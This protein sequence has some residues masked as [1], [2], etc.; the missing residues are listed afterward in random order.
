MEEYNINNIH[1]INSINFIN[2]NDNKIPSKGNN[3]TQINYLNNLQQYTRNTDKKTPKKKITNKYLNSF[4]IPNNTKDS[5]L[6]FDNQDSIPINQLTIHKSSKNPTKIKI[7]NKNNIEGTNSNKRTTAIKTGYVTD[8]PYQ[9]KNLKNSK[10][11]IDVNNNNEKKNINLNKNILEQKNKDNKVLNQNNLKKYI[12]ILKS[13]NANLIKILHRKDNELLDYQKTE[14][15]NE[16]KIKQLTTILYEN[17]NFSKK[18][19]PDGNEVEGGLI[20]DEDN[21]SQNSTLKELKDK[22]D[23]LQKKIEELNNTTKNLKSRYILNLNKKEEEKNKII[24]KY[25][26]LLQEKLNLNKDIQNQNGEI[27]N[28]KN[29]INILKD[30]IEKN[31]KIIE[32]KDDIINNVNKED[33]VLLKKIEQLSNENQKLLEQINSTNRKYQEQKKLLSETNKKLE[34]MK[35]ISRALLEKEKIKALNDVNIPSPSACTIICNKRYNNMVWYLLYKKPSFKSGG[36]K[37]YDNY[38]WVTELILKKEDLQKYNQFEDD[39]DKNKDYIIDL[40]KKLEKKEESINKLDYM[41]KKLASQLQNKTANIKGDNLLS[42]QTK[43]INNYA[44]SFNDNHNSIENELKYKNILEN[45]KRKEKHLNN[46]INQLKEKLDEKNNL[47]NNFPKDIKLID[48]NYHDSGFLDDESF[49]DNNKNEEIKDLFIQ[50]IKPRNIQILSDDNNII[51]T[52][53]GL[54]KSKVSS[55]DD[56]FKEAEKKVDE[57]LANGAGDEDDYDEVK[58]I[59]KQMNFLKEEI[60]DYREKNQKLGTEMKDLFTKIK[61]NDKNRKN[62]VQIC[63]LLAFSPQLVDQIISNKIFKK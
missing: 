33:N 14:M 51:K 8:F 40:Q 10:N 12:Q 55:K 62:I 53:E 61:C 4:S 21:N 63:Q 17:N 46:K 32:K 31:K 2:I 24:K 23:E 19:Y 25:N 22:N 15:E 35:D 54:N 34:E 45:F 41:N 6:F 43:D 48:Q 1:K 56:P 27:E 52:E 36:D 9:S 57:F 30:E 39:D 49:N 50:N 44:N 37:N 16:K 38:F 60:K 11:I 59:T 18:S 29:E 58:M 5:E 47:E 26:N 7:T 20:S 3:I 28:Y 42:K 13:K